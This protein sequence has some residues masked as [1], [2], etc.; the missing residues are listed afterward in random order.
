MESEIYAYFALTKF[1][2]EPE[3]ITAKLGIIP[4][5]TWRVGDL[6][7]PRGTIRKKHNGWRLN[8]KLEKSAELEDHVKSVLE[9]LQVGWLPLVE[10]CSQYYA[11]IA[12]VIYY[13]S[14]S[15]PAIHFDKH[16]MQQ[17]AELNAEIDVDLYLL[18]KN[19]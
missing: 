18:A 14:G 17:V 2:F 13:W 16:I 19:D 10:L 7:T 9:Q 5:E 1:D 6:I 11:E 4:D 12:G 15:V 8:S 3:E